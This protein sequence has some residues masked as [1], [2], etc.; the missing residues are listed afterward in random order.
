[1]PRKRLIESWSRSPYRISN[2]CRTAVRSQLDNQG[3]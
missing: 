2:R 1:M 3:A